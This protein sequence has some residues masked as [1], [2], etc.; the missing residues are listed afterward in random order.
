MK[1]EILKDVLEQIPPVNDKFVD[2]YAK[3]VVLRGQIQK[4]MTTISFNPKIKNTKYFHVK[5]LQFALTE[6][7]NILNIDRKKP[8]EY[9]TFKRTDFE[10]FLKL[11]VLRAKI[12]NS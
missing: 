6:I 9:L 1:S 10:E 7:D 3:L 8:S 11:P 12:K 2:I 5:G 4:E